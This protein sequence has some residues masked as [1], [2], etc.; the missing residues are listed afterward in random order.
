MPQYYTPLG[1]KAAAAQ[2]ELGQAGNELGYL[3]CET[4]R[5]RTQKDV[6]KNQQE[7][8]DIQRQRFLPRGRP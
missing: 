5:P 7:A 3:P 6:L 2:K 1:E 4:Q 8:R